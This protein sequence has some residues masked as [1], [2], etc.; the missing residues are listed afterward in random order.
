[1]FTNFVAPAYAGE[2][3][4]AILPDL[5][6]GLNWYLGGLVSK[7]WIKVN[8]SPV[9]GPVSVVTNTPGV[10]LSIPLANLT[11]GATD[12]DG[13]ALGVGSVNLTSTNGVAVQTNGTFLFYSNA[14]NVA[15]HILYTIDDGRGGSAAA[16]IEIGRGVTAEFLGQLT[17]QGNSVT[18]HFSGAPDATYYLERATALPVWQTISTNIMPANGVVEYI[19][20]FHD[21]VVP[22]EA[23]FYRLRW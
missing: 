9:A 15:D 21:L 17:V 1:V 3:A 8:R 18:I 23:A 2:F 16:A 20:D 19:D 13:D 7:G 10:Q 14:V 22:P 11:T 6:N 4:N 5:T 12:A